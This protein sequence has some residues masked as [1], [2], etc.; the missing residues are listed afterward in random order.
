LTSQR[1]KR[2]FVGATALTWLTVAATPGRAQ[3]T[4]AAG[5]TPPDD[6]PS[7]RVGATIFMDYTFTQKPEITDAAGNT[8]NANAFNVVRSYINITG[9][10]SHLLAFRITPDITRE[11]GAGSSLNGS[12]TFRVKYA[13]AQVNLDDWMPRGSWA[14]FGIQQTPFVDYFEG[15]YRYRFQG[16]IFSEREGYLSS[17]DGGLSFHTNFPQNYGDLH[18]GVYNGETYGRAEANNTKALQMRGTV[19]PLPMAAI[20]RGLRVTLFYD[21]DRVV[22]DAPRNRFIANVTFEHKYLNGGFDYLNTKDQTLPTTAEV[23]GHGVSVWLTPKATNGVEGLVRYDD[24]TVNKSTDARRKRAIVGLA[25]WLPHQGNV[26]T[27]FLLDYEQVTFS[28]FVPAQ[29]K[30]QRIAVHGLVNF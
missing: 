5:Y 13:F 6:T 24:M 12:L 16:T 26:S 23:D 28:D 25:Y 4:P 11:T 8:V 18:V 2:L 15:I 20:M 30:Q 27:A 29:P 10:I 19:R 7:I 1:T 14:R 21:L 17:S 22:N 9:N 3:V